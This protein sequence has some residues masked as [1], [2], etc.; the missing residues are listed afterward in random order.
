MH[1][2]YVR[3]TIIQ[4]GKLPQPDGFRPELSVVWSWYHPP[5]T[6]PYMLVPSA[7]LLQ[8]RCDDK[9]LLGH[10]PKEEGNFPSIEEDI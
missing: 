7:C 5:C 10:R 9:E 4:G 3:D 1:A 6:S 8:V 2:E